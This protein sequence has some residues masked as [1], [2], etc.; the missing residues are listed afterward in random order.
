MRTGTQL[1]ALVASHFGSAG[2]ANGF[3]P[4]D[5][6]VDFM[7]A[8][9]VGLPAFM[10]AVTWLAIARPNA[11]INLP[12]RD[13]WLAPQRRAD[14]IATLRAGILRFGALLVVFLCYMHWLVVRANAAQPARLDNAWFI[15]G[16]VAFLVV[17]M[18]GMTRL[19]AHFRR[20]G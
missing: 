14:T 4:R 8:I 15:G 10:V 11:R 17:L 6:Y 5:A 16:L 20:R 19:L 1:P 2:D 12:H 18:L 3:M 13:Y 9:V 7:L